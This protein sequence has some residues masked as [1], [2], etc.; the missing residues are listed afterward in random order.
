ML[1]VETFKGKEVQKYIP[2]IVKLRIEVFAE[3]PYLYEGNPLNEEKYL[4]K[5]AKKFT[6]CDESVMVVAFD[7]DKVVGVSSGLPLENED[8]AVTK[9]FKES[10]KN[11]KDYFYF[12]ESVLK[13]AYRGRGLGHKFFDEREK[14][15]KGLGRFKKI[16][17]C[18]VIRD[19]NDPRKPGG[20]FQLDNFWK[21]RG[22]EKKRELIAYFSWKEHGDDKET[23]K[24]LCCWT[25]EIS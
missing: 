17:F 25:K 13:K 12:S 23:E 18:A 8:I 3:W 20:Y 5:F 2:E 22:Y 11:I 6:L 19:E 7:G 15:V 1:K 10:G 4:K 14:H 21:K 16:C 24:P 9:P